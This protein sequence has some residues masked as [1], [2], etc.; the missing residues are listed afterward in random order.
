[1]TAARC[2]QGR[3]DHVGFCQRYAIEWFSSGGLDVLIDCRRD[4]Y[5]NDGEGTELN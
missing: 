2:L 5:V 3:V 1:M 4:Q